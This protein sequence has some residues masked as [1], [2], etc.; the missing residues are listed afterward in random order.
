MVKTSSFL[1]IIYLLSK[2]IRANTNLEKFF[3]R[4]DYDYNIYNSTGTE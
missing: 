1:L 3:F 2:F 4:R